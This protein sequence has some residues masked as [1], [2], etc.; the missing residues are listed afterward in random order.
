S[1]GKGIESW[2]DV[3]VGRG[4]DGRINLGRSSLDYLLKERMN[5]A[6]QVASAL[7]EAPGAAGPALN[8]MVEQAGI[9][10]AGIFSTSGNVM[11][12]AGMGGLTATP[13]PPP[14]TALRRARLQQTYAEPEQTAAGLVLRVVVPVNSRDRLDPLR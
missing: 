10:E 6:P 8:R 14:A 11:A 4:F 7:A 2:L 13:E 9:Y 1:L 5:R 3:R 12:V